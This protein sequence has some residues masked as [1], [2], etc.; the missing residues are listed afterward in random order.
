M[1]K[2]RVIITKNTRGIELFNRVYEIPQ[3]YKVTN[4]LLEDPDFL[5]D[6]LESE[7]NINDP[8]LEWNIYFESPIEI[9]KDNFI[10]EIQQ[11]LIY[12]NLDT[13]Q[14][15]DTI[16]ELLAAIGLHYTPINPMPEDLKAYLLKHLYNE[17]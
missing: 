14:L 4:S 6:L 17:L 11:E 3:P 16:Y 2:Y 15:T 9:D 8:T 5:N 13:E 1:N 12:N 7:I 10:K